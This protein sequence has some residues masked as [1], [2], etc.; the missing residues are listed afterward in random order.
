M[1][2]DTPSGNGDALS[3]ARLPR[4]SCRGSRYRAAVS[5]PFLRRDVRVI[6]DMRQ[7]TSRFR[8]L[9]EGDLLQLQRMAW[10][11]EALFET[12]FLPLMKPINCNAWE[13]AGNYPAPPGSPA[14]RLGPAGRRGLCEDVRLPHRRHPRRARSHQCGEPG[15]RTHQD[16]RVGRNQL[17]AGGG[18]PSGAVNLPGAGTAIV[19]ARSRRGRR[20]RTR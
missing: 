3:S 17:G 20:V 1:S 9:G 6:G 18:Y 15:G 5:A 12:D 16:E 2:E 8:R 10:N 11:T 13:F 7:T 14:T 19:P 4:R